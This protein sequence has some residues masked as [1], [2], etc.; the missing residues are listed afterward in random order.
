MIPTDPTERARYYQQKAT[1][2]I[3]KF[4]ARGRAELEDSMVRA[5]EALARYNKQRDEDEAAEEARC[6]ALTCPSSYMS[7]D[8]D[9]EDLW[10][11]RNIELNPNSPSEDL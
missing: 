5:R 8:Y 2:I 10:D 6:A 3:A 11:D 9:D 4:E 7:Q 1:A